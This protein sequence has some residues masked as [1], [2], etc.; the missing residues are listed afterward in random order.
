MR[1]GAAAQICDEVSLMSGTGLR[2]LA[3][4]LLV[5]L[6]LYVAFAGGR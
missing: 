1:V 4:I 2:R 5:M 6:I 3:Y